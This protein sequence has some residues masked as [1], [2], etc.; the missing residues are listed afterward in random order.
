MQR[1]ITQALRLTREP[2][3]DHNPLARPDGGWY[4][5]KHFDPTDVLTDPRNWAV[6]KQFIIFFA[7]ILF[8]PVGIFL[9]VEY[10]LRTHFQLGLNKSTTV[11]A[12]CSMLVLQALMFTYARLAAIEDKAEWH[13]GCNEEIS[14]KL[15]DN[16]AK[17]KEAKDKEAKAMDKEAKAKDNEIRDEDL[18][19]KVVP[20][21]KDSE[22]GKT[23]SSKTPVGKSLSRKKSRSKSATEEEVIAG[24]QQQ[25]NETRTR[26][27]KPRL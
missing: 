5:G 16:E 18:G 26:V 6:W 25:H 4:P 20:S 24:I 7:S 19:D 11:G 2:Q 13:K 1:L 10:V 12:V 8:L 21:E 14:D 15:E 9:V 22:K 3:T 17:G 27:R 23:Q